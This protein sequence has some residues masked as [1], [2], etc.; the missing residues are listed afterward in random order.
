LVEEV[1]HLRAEATGLRQHGGHDPVGGPPQQVP[2]EGAA[3]A[4]AK[5][6]ELR[7]AQVIHQAEVVVG[8]GVPGTV[9]LERASG[10]ATVGVA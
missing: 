3:D 6:H 10:V 5:H 4:E 8:V 2:D 7:D 9:D 1:G